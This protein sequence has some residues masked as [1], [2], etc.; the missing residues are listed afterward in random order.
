MH[1]KS[2]YFIA[3]A[4]SVPEERSG[5][6]VTPITR[7]SDKSN[8]FG[9]PLR[10]RVI[11]ARLYLQVF[12]IEFYFRKLGKRLLNTQNNTQAILF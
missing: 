6:E 7:T 5:E 11:E 10:L 4:T 9:G 1:T 2:T 8:I 12:I 3:Q